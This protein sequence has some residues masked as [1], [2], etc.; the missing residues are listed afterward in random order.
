LTEQLDISCE[1]CEDKL[2][3]TIDHHTIRHQASELRITALIDSLYILVDPEDDE[4][5]LIST[6]AYTVELYEEF[7]PLFNADEIEKEDSGVIVHNIPDECSEDVKSL[8]D[9]IDALKE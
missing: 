5:N 8:M 7:L 3:M 4:G 2:L 1:N 9:I 6:E